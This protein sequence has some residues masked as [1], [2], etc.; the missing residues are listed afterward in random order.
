[1][2]H[3]NRTLWEAHKSDYVASYRASAAV[4]SRIGFAA[5]TNHAWL[6]PDRAVQYTDWE[7]GDRV[8]VNFGNQ[9]FARPGKPSLAAH[10]SHSR[11]SEAL[12]YGRFTPLGK[13][14]GSLPRL[15]N[16]AHEPRHQIADC[17]PLLLHAVAMAQRDGVAQRRVPFA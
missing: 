13:V 11:G 12:S 7:T 4:R 1:M 9:P 14:R 17:H 8:I 15:C 2:W 6:T 10:P 3:I 5:M 16:G